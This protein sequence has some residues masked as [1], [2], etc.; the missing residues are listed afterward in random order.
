[1]K[2]FRYVFLISFFIIAIELNAKLVISYTNLDLNNAPKGYIELEVKQNNTLLEDLTLD[3]FL[4]VEGTRARKPDSIIKLTKTKYALFWTSPYEVYPQYIHPQKP[5]DIPMLSLTVVVS[6]AGETER[7]NFLYENPGLPMLVIKERKSGNVIKEISFYNTTKYQISVVAFVNKNT[8]T[9]GLKLDSITFTSPYF[10]YNW[11]GTPFDMTSRPPMVMEFS[12]HYLVDVMYNPPD[13]RPLRALM[14]F[15]YNN[16]MVKN[17]ALVGGKFQVKQTTMLQL[18]QPNGNEILTPC[19][20]YDIKWKSHSKD[21]PVIVEFSADGGSSWQQIAKVTDSTY[22]WTV[23]N[24]E[25]EKAL[26][27]VRQEFTKFNEVILKEDWSNITKIAFNSNGTRAIGANTQG[28]I[29]EFD[30]YN[31]PNSPINRYFENLSGGTYYNIAVEYI[32]NDEI[33]YFYKKNLFSNPSIAYFKVGSSLPTKTI[34]LDFDVNKVYKDPKNRFFITKSSFEPKFNILSIDN[35]NLLHSVITKMP[36]S[37]ISFNKSGDTI[38]IIEIDGRITI[39]EV[40]SVNNFT[41]LNEF[42]LDGIAIP[43]NIKFSPNGKLLAISVMQED[44]SG[45]DTYLYDL[46]QNSVVRIFRPA[47]NTPIEIDFS[48]SSGAI[49][50]GSPNLD[51]IVMYDLTGSDA[52]S[53]LSGHPNTMNDMKMDPEGFAILSSSSGEANFKHRSFS[54]PELDASDNNFR[55]I[56]ANLSIAELNIQPLIIGTENIYRFSTHICNNSEVPVYFY[57]ISPKNGTHFRVLNTNLVDTLLPNNCYDLLIDF[58]PLDTGIIND[59]IIINSC[60]KNFVVPISF[61]SLDRKLTLLNASGYSFDETCIKNKT[62]KKFPLFRNDDTVNVLINK[63]EIELTLSHIFHVEDII[64]DTIIKPNETLYVNFSFQPQELKEYVGKILIYHSNQSNVIK[65]ATIKGKGIGTFLTVSHNK[66]MFINEINIRT[67]EVKN[68]S[69][70][71]IT[72]TEVSFEPQGFFLLENSLPIKLE[73]NKSI[74]LSIKR[75][76]FASEPVKLQFVA[77]PC[78]V[79]SDITIDNYQASSVLEISQTQADPRKNAKIEIKF[80]NAENNPYQGERFFEG[81]IAINPRI[82]LPQSIYSTFGNAK[83]LANDIIN[84]KRHIKFR[85]DGDFNH[86]NG[87][88]C[89]ISGIAGLADII[90]SPIEWVEAPYW[91]TSVNTLTKNGEFKL[92]NICENR[93]ISTNSTFIK[94]IKPIPA[95]DKINITI[96]AK[97]QQNGSIQIVDLFGN[98]VLKTDDILIKAGLNNFSINVSYISNGTYRLILNTNDSVISEKIV[99]M[100]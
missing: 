19:Q 94:S 48:P 91:G 80:S 49:V 60:F 98:T 33:A 93:L 86:T 95:S 12:D 20:T 30:I 7:L 21:Q 22:K 17:I 63:I 41:K 28:K 57:N 13:D 36:I 3:N 66:L 2:A 100:R 1:M 45:T 50:I 18:I 53:V 32:N 62:I 6:Y 52:K 14:Q 35:G 85:I 82:F 34:N 77:E 90:Q 40:K 65:L 31:Q 75:V 39:Y 59:E 81:E 11:Q 47:V 78:L 89:E 83:I 69:Q 68:T 42:Y 72:L 9:D 70:Q 92:I 4:I 58:I 38:A 46:L 25:T 67:I 8:I 56:A 44:N 73:I 61:K 55:I 15:H 54:Y 79:S 97:Q 74:V 64:K 27:R 37:S 76:Q 24:V 84:N 5:D 10:S 29:Y 71:A 87:T 88:L 26:V 96:E 51:Q 16:G 99:I 43:T 23:P